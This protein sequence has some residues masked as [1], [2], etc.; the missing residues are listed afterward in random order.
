MQ[1]RTTDWQEWQVIKNDLNQV[2]FEWNTHRITGKKTS[3]APMGRPLTMFELPQLYGTRD[4]LFAVSP[5]EITM[6]QEESLRE[7]IFTRI[8]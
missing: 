5:S 2:C 7:E 3:I 6:C 1:G 8:L 4:Y